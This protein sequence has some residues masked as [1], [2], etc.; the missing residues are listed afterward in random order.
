MRIHQSLPFE[1]GQLAEAKSFKR[2]YRGAWFRC[3][4]FPNHGVI[5]MNATSLLIL[6]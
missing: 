1:I 6:L 2:G 5:D 4:V 3:K